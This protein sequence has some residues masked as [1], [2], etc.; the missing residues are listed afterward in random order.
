MVQEK[1]ILKVE[2]NYLNRMREKII[3]YANDSLRFGKK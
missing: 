3:Q 1:E 2:I